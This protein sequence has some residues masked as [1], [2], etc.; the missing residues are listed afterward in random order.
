VTLDRPDTHFRPVPGIELGAAEPPPPGDRFPV[1]ASR[2]LVGLAVALGATLALV[3]VLSIGYAIAGVENIGDNKSF[4]FIATLFGDFA[5]VGA[6][7]GMVADRGRP[8]LSTFGFRPFSS[9]AIGWVVVAFFGYLVLAGLYSELVHPPPDKL[10]DELGADESVLLA[11]LTGVF[12]I[13]VAPFAEEFFFRGFLFQALRKSWGVWLAA[14]A[15]G[16][17]FGLI[18]FELG[19]LV[20]LAILGTVLALL[21]HKTDSLW[22]CI[23][24]HALNNTL[25]FAVTV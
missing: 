21:F 11:V 3:I 6:A 14:P 4:E 20:Q 19:K 17:I 8:S 16:L 13:G 7:W 24:L 9:S 25:A 10:P 23:M 1:G 5:L 18:H 15:S 12:V 22:A 2:G